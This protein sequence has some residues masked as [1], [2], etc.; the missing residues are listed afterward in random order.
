MLGSSPAGIQRREEMQLNKIE[1]F[2]KNTAISKVFREIDYADELESGMRNTNKY[3]KFYFGGTST[4]IE[5][6]IF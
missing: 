1:A 3:T 6:N 2:Y 5:D 4:F